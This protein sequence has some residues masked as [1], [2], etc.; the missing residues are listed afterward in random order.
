MTTIGFLPCPLPRGGLLATVDAVA[1][2]LKSPC[3]GSPDGARFGLGAE[4]Y[5]HAGV[6]GALYRPDRSSFPSWDRQ[7]ASQILL[8]ARAYRFI[9]RFG[10]AF[11]IA[12]PDLAHS[13][14]E[15]RAARMASGL[16]MEIGEISFRLGFG[17]ADADDGIAAG[18]MPMQENPDAVL[19]GDYLAR[20][21]PYPFPDHER[22]PLR[23]RDSLGALGP[24]VAGVRL[25]LGRYR[26]ATL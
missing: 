23:S 8:Q 17:A 11:E 26:E 19:F 9:T 5:A 13:G 1:I 4:A 22:R 25:A 2:A 7:I 24:R 21:Y 14:K 10:L 20:Y 16:D 3:A 6:E 18:W 12:R 15:G